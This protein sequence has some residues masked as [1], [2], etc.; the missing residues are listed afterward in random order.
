[1]HYLVLFLLFTFL[2]PCWKLSSVCTACP[3]RIR[4]RTPHARPSEDRDCFPPSS[5]PGLSCLQF[6][7]GLTPPTSVVS[8]ACPRMVGGGRLASPAS[9]TLCETEGPR[10]WLTATGGNGGPKHQ[11]APAFE[12][13]GSPP[14]RPAG[15]S[16]AIVWQKLPHSSTCSH[17]ELD[18]L[19]LHGVSCEALSVLN[20]LLNY[21]CAN[22]YQL[23]TSLKWHERCYFATQ[24]IDELIDVLFKRMY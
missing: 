19:I 21:S 6:S 8:E 15:I 4:A 3:H 18:S 14:E 17:Y 11:H 20:L 16:M 13:S 1:M 2:I 23:P 5:A 12:E 9:G 7:V 22:S 24:L 10:Q